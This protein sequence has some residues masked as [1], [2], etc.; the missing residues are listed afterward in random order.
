MLASDP[1]YIVASNV[2]GNLIFRRREITNLLL[3][4]IRLFKNIFNRYRMILIY[5]LIV[6]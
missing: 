1:I 2:L 5:S 6:S 3:I 4:K